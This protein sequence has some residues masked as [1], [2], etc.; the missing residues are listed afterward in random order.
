MR[1]QSWGSCTSGNTL[2]FHWKTILAPMRILD[3]IVVHEMVHLVEKNHTPEFWEIIKA[4]L[5]DYEERKEWLKINGKYL[6]I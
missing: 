6:D 5:P 2:N 1:K 4:I 3:Y